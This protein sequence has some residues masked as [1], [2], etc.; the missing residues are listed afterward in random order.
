MPRTW[1]EARVAAPDA[2]LLMPPAS[3]VEEPSEKRAGRTTTPPAPRSAPNRL[4]LGVIVLCVLILAGLAYPVVHFLPVVHRDALE[5]VLICAAGLTSL[6]VAS[7]RET[8]A[9]ARD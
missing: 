2:G 8:K 3:R 1:P 5:I 4:G 6:M 7:F 9:A